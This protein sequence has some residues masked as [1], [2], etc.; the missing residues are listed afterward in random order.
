MFWN[1]KENWLVL[2]E[3]DGCFKLVQQSKMNDED[4]FCGIVFMSKDYE[5]AD[6]VCRILSTIQ[7]KLDIKLDIIKLLLSKEISKLD[8]SNKLTVKEGNLTIDGTCYLASSIIEKNANIFYAVQGNYPNITISKY[9]KVA[10][11]SFN[12]CLRQKEGNLALLPK[13]VCFNSKADAIIYQNKL[14]Q[15]YSQEKSKKK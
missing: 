12:Y 14:I 4:R 13:T 11:D 6:N 7:N 15:Q 9:E 10:E 1:K 2:S 3:Q 5:Q 8:L